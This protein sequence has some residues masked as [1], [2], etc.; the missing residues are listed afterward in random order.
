MSVPIKPKPDQVE[1][2]DVPIVFKD[3]EDIPVLLTNAFV[4]QPSNDGTFI[5]VAAQATPPILYGNEE[6]QRRQLASVKSAP[7]KV[8]ARLAFTPPK[9]IELRNVLNTLID[10]LEKAKANAEALEHA[11]KGGSQ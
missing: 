1:L 7:G 3:A 8:V 4:V 5:L 2:R 10:A 11:S 9:L 6:Q